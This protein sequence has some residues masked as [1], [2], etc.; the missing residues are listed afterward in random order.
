SAPSAPAPE[1]L[2]PLASLLPPEGVV[3]SRLREVASRAGDLRSGR[4]DVAGVRGCA[5]AA[6]AAASARGGRRVIYVTSDREG[7]RQVDE[8]LGFL[9]RGTADDDAEESGTG[10]VL[11]FAA[12]ETSPW[13]DVSP[14]RRAAMSRMATL[15]HLAHGLPFRALVIPASALVRKVVPRAAL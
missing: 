3:A 12:S 11:I 6:L 7:A 1:E 10:D 13:A 14:D 2:E 15:F 4:L 9:V 5:G 8:D